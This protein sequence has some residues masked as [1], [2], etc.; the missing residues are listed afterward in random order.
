[1]KNP[2]K[3]RIPYTSWLKDYEKEMQ[4]PEFRAGAEKARERIETA[5]AILKMRHKAR[6]SQKEVADKLNISQSAIA[7]IEQGGQNLTIETL[8][9][10][11]EL[12]GKKVKIRFV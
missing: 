3:K 8:R 1:M 11:A 4:N 5:Y 9:K 10:I 6:L 2:K 7:R 12:F